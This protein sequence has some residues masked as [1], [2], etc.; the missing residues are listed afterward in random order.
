MRICLD[1]GLMTN[2]AEVHSQLQ[3]R[4]GLP[5][6]YGRNLDALFDLLTAWGEPLEILFVRWGMVEANLGLYAEALGE[7][8]LDAA[9]ENPHLHVT[10][11]K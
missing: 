3:E 1:G 9:R 4:L 5:E 10:I 8:L 6:Y 2:R 7:T 11:E